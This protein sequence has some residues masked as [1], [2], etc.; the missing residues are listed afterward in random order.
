MYQG[1]RVEVRAQHAEVGTPIPLC[2]SQG[3]NSGC[4]T[5]LQ[6]SLFAEP[7]R[8]PFLLCSR[9]LAVSCSELTS[10]QG[11]VLRNLSACDPHSRTGYTWAFPPPLTP[12]PD[13]K[14]QT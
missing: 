12:T 10:V 4:Q 8:Q 9:M 13:T 7:S 14:D 11:P 1:K 3:M 6:V 2:K 5:W